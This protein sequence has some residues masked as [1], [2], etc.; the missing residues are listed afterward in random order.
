MDLAQLS[1]NRHASAF[2]DIACAYAG[3]N[4]LEAMQA[5]TFQSIDK[6]LATDRLYIIPRFITLAQKIQ[7]KDHHESHAAAIAEYAQY[8]LQGRA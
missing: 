5:S 8:A 2:Q 3:V 6:A 4:E 1:E 7:E